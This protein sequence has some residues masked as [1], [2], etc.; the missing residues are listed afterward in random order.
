MT[1]TIRRARRR[2]IMRKN[3]IITCTWIYVQCSV[4]VCV[5]GWVFAVCVYVCCVCVSMCVCVCCVCVSVCVCVCPCVCVRIITRAKWS[6]NITL[7]FSVLLFLQVFYCKHLHSLYI[8]KYLKI[9]YLFIHLFI[10]NDGD[11][12]VCVWVGF[13][14]LRVGSFCSQ[15]R[16]TDHLEQVH[17]S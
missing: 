15:K 16:A 7:I 9:Y 10:Q 13:P 17:V 11:L 3:T 1:L 4:C 14:S 8:S 2:T 6:L 12:C 5:C